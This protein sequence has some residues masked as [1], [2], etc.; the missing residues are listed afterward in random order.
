[1]ATISFNFERY[2]IP[3]TK[4]E[5]KSYRALLKAVENL[6]TI[7]KV[8]INRADN[9]FGMPDSSPGSL[10]TELRA[11]L[12]LA[13]YRITKIPESQQVI[14]SFARAQTKRLLSEKL[15]IAFPETPRT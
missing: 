14:G 11:E 4:T 12:E 8:T 9:K 1:M 13:G 2:T 7:G 10:A 5:L 3:Y 6:K 15:K